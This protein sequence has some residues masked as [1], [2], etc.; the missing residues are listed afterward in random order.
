MTQQG[1][2]LLELMIVL[3]IVA[4]LAAIAAPDMGMVSKQKRL[5][6][7]AA[8]LQDALASARTQAV[9]R[10]TVVSVQGIGGNSWLNGVESYIPSTGQAGIALQNSDT[11][12]E[13]FSINNS[14]GITGGLNQVL[15]FNN[16]GGLAVAVGSSQNIK[17]C[18]T[19]SRIQQGVNL[20]I[21]IAGRIQ[22]RSVACP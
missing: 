16:L 4:I 9:M 21:N 19:D 7:V 11:Q 6:S 14:T 10:S 3:A 8:T 15:S 12:L 20:N 17:I 18:S 13:T 5:E 22:K 1:F 2:S